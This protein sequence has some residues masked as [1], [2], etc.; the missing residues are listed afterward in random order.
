MSTEQALTARIFL[1]ALTEGG[2]WS[3][4]EMAMDLRV[5]YQSAKDAMSSM[6]ET[7]SL[8]RHEKSDEAKTLTYS[9]TERC[10]LPS[11]LTLMEVTRALRKAGET[12]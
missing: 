9:V 6:S 4:R 8:I 5:D 1:H 7:G 11:G 2:R 12:V 3:V 10:R